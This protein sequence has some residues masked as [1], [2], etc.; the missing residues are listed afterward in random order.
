MLWYGLH[1]HQGHGTWVTLC[2]FLSILLI[3]MCIPSTHTRTIYIG[4]WP[5]KLTHTALDIHQEVITN[6][7][8]ILRSI[9]KNP[10]VVLWTFYEL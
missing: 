9:E 5:R 10:E 1:A 8:T 2:K 3:P 4:R 7:I 6:G